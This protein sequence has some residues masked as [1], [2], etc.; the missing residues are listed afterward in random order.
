MPRLRYLKSRREDFEEDDFNFNEPENEGTSSET[1]PSGFEGVQ[2]EAPSGTS[3]LS[4]ASVIASFTDEQLKAAIGRCK[5]NLILFEAELMA[6]AYQNKSHPNEARPQNFRVRRR[7]SGIPSSEDLPKRAK[8]VSGSDSV[9]AVV[10][11][12]KFLRKQGIKNSQE[13]MKSWLKIIAEK[14][15]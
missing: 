12:E 3:W 9:Q 11:A 13:I 7:K 5:A 15:E 10:D 1:S 4:N 6:R 8:R 14:G 2:E